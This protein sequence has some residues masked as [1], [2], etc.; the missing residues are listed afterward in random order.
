MKLSVIIGVTQMLFGY[1]F[2]QL[3]NI[4]YYL[5]IILKGMNAFHFSEP[6]DFL[7]EVIPQILFMV[8]TFG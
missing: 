7:F 5:G 6:I 3:K 8:C 1:Y 2:K 4:I